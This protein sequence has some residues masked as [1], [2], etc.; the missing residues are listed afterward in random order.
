MF[1]DNTDDTTDNFLMASDTL[2][3]SQ[4]NYGYSMVMS[5]D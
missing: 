3:L 2:W 1:D 5:G 4:I